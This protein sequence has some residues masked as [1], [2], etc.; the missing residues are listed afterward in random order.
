MYLRA[1]GKAVPVIRHGQITELLQ[2]LTAG[3]Q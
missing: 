1:P 2:V 3:K